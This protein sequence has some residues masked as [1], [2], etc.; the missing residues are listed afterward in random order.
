MGGPNGLEPST[1]SVSRMVSLEQPISRISY[2]Q[3]KSLQFQLNNWNVME[4]AWMRCLP[5]HFNDRNSSLPAAGSVYLM[6]RCARFASLFRYGVEGRHA[7][8]TTRTTW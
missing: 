7:Q 3:A 1:S 4:R 5:Q 8:A 6:T 2:L